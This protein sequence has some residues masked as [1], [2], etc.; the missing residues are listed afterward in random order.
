MVLK[1]FFIVLNFLEKFNTIKPFKTIILVIIPYGLFYG[2]MIF[3]TKYFY[4]KYGV[5]KKR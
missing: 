2:L 4:N 3:L 1:K 5:E